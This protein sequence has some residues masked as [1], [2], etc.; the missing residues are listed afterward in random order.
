M[1][2]HLV[3]Y[4]TLYIT[5]DWGQYVSTK[6]RKTTCGCRSGQAKVFPYLCYPFC[7]CP[8]SPFCDHFAFSVLRYFLHWP[9][10]V[11]AGKLLKQQNSKCTGDSSGWAEGV[12]L[13]QLSWWRFGGGGGHY[14]RWPQVNQFFMALDCWPRWFLG[15]WPLTVLNFNHWPLTMCTFAEV[16][17][18]MHS[19]FTPSLVYGVKMCGHS[20]DYWVYGSAPPSV[21]PVQFHSFA[22]KVVCHYSSLAHL[23][24]DFQYSSKYTRKNLDFVSN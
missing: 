15:L 1:K 18:R 16:Y 3:L 12:N 11:Y 8:L 21:V 17:G 20:C 13:E 7:V 24:P 14:P 5:W 23:N 4:H 6:H 2:C 10:L 22:V 19:N 9:D